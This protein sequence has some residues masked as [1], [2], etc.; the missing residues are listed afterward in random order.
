MRIADVERGRYRHAVALR[1]ER[2]RSVVRGNAV[3]LK[4]TKA[5]SNWS[6]VLVLFIPGLLLGCYQSVEADEDDAGIDVGV[7]VGVLDEPDTAPDVEPDTETDAEPVVEPDAETDAEPDVENT[8]DADEGCIDDVFEDESDAPHTAP[9]LTIGTPLEAQICPGDTDLYAFNLEAGVQYEITAT[10]WD[11]ETTDIDVFLR[12]LDGELLGAGEAEATGSE[13]FEVCSHLP[14]RFLLEIVGVDGSSG[15]YVLSVSETDDTCCIEDEFEAHDGS[16]DPV[17]M[18]CGVGVDAVVCNGDEDWWSFEVPDAMVMIRLDLE[19]EPGSGDLDIQVFDASGIRIGSATSES[20]DE[21]TTIWLSAAGTYLVRV[22]AFFNV[23][24]TYHLDCGE[25]S[26]SLCE[27]RECPTGTI[28]DP[29]V[30]CVNEACSPGVTVCPE[31]HFCPRPGCAGA[32]GACVMACLSSAD[33][34]PGY[35]CKIFEEGLGCARTGAG[36][37]GEVCANFADCA[38]E[39]ICVCPTGEDGYCAVINCESG[40]D[41]P[42]ETRPVFPTRCIDVGS[43]SLCLMDCLSGDSLCD[44]HPRATCVVSRDVIGSAAWVCVLPEFSVPEF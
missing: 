8:S 31:E 39:R 34:R 9:V 38:G 25:V 33:C 12:D 29:M 19:C 22:F 14:G 42:T 18:V 13:L 6:I 17:P 15:P 32:E 11:A 41:C 44:I 27:D 43:G 35:E 28:C 10:G 23:S 30:G 26:T 1:F 3:R 4:L 5:I 21:S 20:C 24:A 2:E 7:D 16:D 40:A 37:T 36:E